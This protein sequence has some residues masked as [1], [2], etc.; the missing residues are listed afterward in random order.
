MSGGIAYVLELDVGRLQRA[1]RRPRALSD[2]TDEETVRELLARARRAHR[3]D[4]GAEAPR[5]LGRARGS[6]R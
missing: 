3:L 2:P 4:R 6:R 5:R 1:E